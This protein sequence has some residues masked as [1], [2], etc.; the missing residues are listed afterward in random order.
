MSGLLEVDGRA[1]PISNLDK[2]LW[3]AA[4]FTKGAML[5]YYARVSPALLPHLEGRPVTLRRFPDGVEEVGWYQNECPAGAPSW[6][7]TR[8]VE[9]PSGTTWQFCALDDLAALLWVVN[10]ATVELHPFFVRSERP[11]EATAVVFDL[12]PGPPADIVD[13]CRAALVLRETL[14]EI[15]LAAF[16]KTSGSVGLHVVVPLNC[17]H[18]WPEAKA[19]ARHVAR[20]LTAKDP[21]RFVDRQSRA[22]RRGKVLVDWLQNDPMRSTVAPY[23]L[24]AYGWPTVSAP[25][26]WDEVELAAAEQ[27]PEVL[28]VEPD[29]AVK[30]IERHGDLFRPVLELEQRLP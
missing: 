25:V 17:P 11:A 13:C 26:T 7:R 5:D 16:A 10:L 4:G 2:V 9:W 6:L 3:P 21:E 29:D 22:L 20:H 18:S 28:T 19:F 1:V 15:G 24:R 8:V 14:A 23:S 27:R 12:D 30:T